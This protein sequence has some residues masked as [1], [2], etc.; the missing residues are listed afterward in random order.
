MLF[1]KHGFEKNQ[2]PRSFGYTFH[3]VSCG[4]YINFGFHSV[5]NGF[6]YVA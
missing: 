5:I 2:L 1:Q 6:H 4:F 3:P